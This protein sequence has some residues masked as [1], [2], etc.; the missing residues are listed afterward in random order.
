MKIIAEG[1]VRSSACH[2]WYVK[3]EFDK[4][5]TWL[6]NLVLIIYLFM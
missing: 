6:K 3:G 4:N 2:K 1:L 5:L